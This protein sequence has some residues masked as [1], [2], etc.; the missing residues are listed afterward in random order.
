M[1]KIRLCGDDAAEVE[2]AAELLETLFPAMRFSGA[3][4]G[5][6]PKYAKDPKFLSYGEPR[7]KNG[8]PVK[9]DITAA[10]DKVKAL[11]KQTTVYSRRIPKHT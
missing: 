3:R 10:A 2:Q 4:K 1:V 7:T 11:S 5:N 6:N 9:V 8:Q